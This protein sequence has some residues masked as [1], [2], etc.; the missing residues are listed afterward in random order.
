MIIIKYIKVYLYK[1]YSK[2]FSLKFK[3]Y[4]KNNFVWF[5]V[6][7]IGKNNIEI[8]SN[9]VIN[10]FT[11]MWGA[12]GIIIGNNVMI[13]SNVVITSL[14]HDYN[15]TNMR[16]SPIIKK[17]V[18]IGDDVWIGAGAIILPG[19]NIGKGAVVGAGA[20]VTSDVPE[21]AIVIGNPAKVLKIRAVLH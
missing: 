1:I 21:F 7:I 13:A 6:K 4:G 3:N 19:I 15:S 18:I 11:H 9:V 17:K 20:V 14:T 10:S 16:F 8:G 5:P 2:L 12:G